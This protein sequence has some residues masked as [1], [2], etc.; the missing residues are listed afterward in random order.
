MN[1]IEAGAYGGSVLQANGLGAT[2]G[3]IGITASD[4][5][6]SVLVA[7]GFAGS[8]KAAVGVAASTTYIENKVRAVVDG[9][10]V[11]TSDGQVTIAGGV[12]SP[13]RRRIPRPSASDLR[14]RAAD[15]ESSSVINVTVGGAGSGKFAAVRRISVNTINNTIEAV[16]TNGSSID[17][18]APSA[19]PRLTPP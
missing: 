18:T 19:C 10:N 6:T 4:K 8:S 2:T 7:G 14:R 3:D 16:V 12:G 13:R 1:T 11:T 17:S 9:S 5:T 15:D